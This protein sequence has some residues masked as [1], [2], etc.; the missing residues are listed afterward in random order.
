MS[1]DARLLI[2]AVVAQV[3]LTLIVGV[4]MMIMRGRDFGRGLDPQSVAMR[5]QKYSPRAT[6]FAYNFSNQFEVPVL[7]YVVAI[8]FLIASRPDLIVTIAAWVFALSRIVHALIHTTGN[9][10][11]WRGAAYFV[12][13]IAIWVL[14]IW[15][16]IQFA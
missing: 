15:F 13:V 12:G 14:L 9:I 8:L 3:L 2:W 4:G 5:E 11:V 10:V 16:I 7:F 1:L 6:Q